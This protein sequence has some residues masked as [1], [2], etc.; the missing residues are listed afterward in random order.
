MAK[1]PTSA[2]Q[3]VLLALIPFTDSNLK[4]AF[5]PNA[6][7][8]DL[9]RISGI[10]NQTLRSAYSRAKHRHDIIYEN[11]AVQLS[12]RARQQ[13]QP[14]IAKKIKNGL[15]MVIFDIPEGLTGRRRSFRTVLQSLEFQQVQKSVWVTQNDHRAI[16]IDT[17]DA[18]A[19][20][21]YVEVYEAAKVN[22]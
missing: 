6:F 3:Y 19:I 12:L 10:K 16:I 15:L 4:L 20:H 7:F 22:I 11:G 5:K 9:E 13:V 14:F 1:R 2:L 17:I 8:N 21:D 18:L